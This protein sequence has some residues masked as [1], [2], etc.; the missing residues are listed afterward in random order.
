MF[1]ENLLFHGHSA[2]GQLEPHQPLLIAKPSE[3]EDSDEID[4]N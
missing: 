2:M 3:E 4:E 1:D